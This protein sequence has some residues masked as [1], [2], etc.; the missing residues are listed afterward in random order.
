MAANSRYSRDGGRAT[1][2]R[3][4]GRRQA[5][6]TGTKRFGRCAKLTVR[7]AGEGAFTLIEMV[8]VL[9]LIGILIAMAV[10]LFVSVTGAS[11]RSACWSNQRNLEYALMRWKADHLDE[12]FVTASCLPGDGEAYI[13][14][15]GNVAG[16]E[17]RSLAPYF[18]EGS[19]VFRCPSSGDAAKGAFGNYEYITDGVKVTCLTDNQIGLKAG[20][21]PFEHDR[22][23]GNGWS[24][25]RGEGDEGEEGTPQEGTPQGDNHEDVTAELIQKLKEYYEKNGKYPSGN[26]EKALA[27]LGLDPEEWGQPVNHILYEPSGSKLQLSPEDGYSFTVVDK[28]GKQQTITSDDNSS[29]IYD[30]KTDKWYYKTVSPKREI[31]ISTLEVNGK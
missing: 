25:A 15:N 1:G 5:A 4:E 27:E 8:M 2:R 26:V 7:A 12:D 11:E 3:A 14:I 6:N 24:H 10:P 30:A 21:V 9:L 20:G 16:D 19:S 23:S 18:E 29:L 17:E 22:P 13:D 28:D 31:D